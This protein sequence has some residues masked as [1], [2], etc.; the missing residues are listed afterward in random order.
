M[1]PQPHRNAGAY[2]DAG[3]F[4]TGT[5]SVSEREV[6]ATSLR[7]PPVVPHC[8]Y[9]SLSDD[10][11]PYLPRLR[12]KSLPMEESTTVARASVETDQPPFLSVRVIALLAFVAIFAALVAVV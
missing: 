11:Q 9:P 8:R 6:H 12:R 3:R 7:N 1:K 10:G 2:H 4:P 5:C